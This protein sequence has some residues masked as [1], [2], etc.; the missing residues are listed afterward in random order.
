MFDI[1]KVVRLLCVP[2]NSRWNAG[3]RHWTA[4]LELRCP[5]LLASHCKLE[6]NP[7]TQ[8]WYRVD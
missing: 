7:D 1:G 3:V 4:E 8:E 2:W 5:W 6:W